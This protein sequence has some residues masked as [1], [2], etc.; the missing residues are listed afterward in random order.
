LYR[1]EADPAVEVVSSL[2]A[3]WIREAVVDRAVSVVF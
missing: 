3:F 1:A 2:L